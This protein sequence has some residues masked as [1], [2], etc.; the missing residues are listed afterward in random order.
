MSE[1]GDGFEGG[2]DFVG[3]QEVGTLGDELFEVRDGGGDGIKVG[4][5]LSQI[6]GVSESGLGEL[7]LDGALGVGEAREE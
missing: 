1:I 3:G 6:G 7:R 5:E 2:T 4:S